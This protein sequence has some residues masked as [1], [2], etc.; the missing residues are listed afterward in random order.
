MRETHNMTKIREKCSVVRMA[1]KAKGS[2]PNVVHT[3][4]DGILSNHR[5]TEPQAS[6]LK[7]RYV[8]MFHTGR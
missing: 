2:R 6:R 3:R 8:W 5:S 7:N 4:P 1:K